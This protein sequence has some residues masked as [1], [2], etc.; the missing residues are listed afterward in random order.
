MVNII[1]N[2]ESFDFGNFN[3]S[4][5]TDFNEFPPEHLERIQVLSLR[6]ASIISKRM[7]SKMEEAGKEGV[8]DPTH[9]YMACLV[10]YLAHMQV[11]FNDLLGYV[12]KL[13]R[14]LDES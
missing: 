10:E 11:S 8:D 12:S 1:N 2:D 14:T 7:A 13:G 6:I 9:L 5:L 4:I 3:A